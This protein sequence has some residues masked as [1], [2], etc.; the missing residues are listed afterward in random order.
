MTVCRF[1]QQGCCRFGNACRFEHVFAQ[2]YS[3]QGQQQNNPYKVVNNSSQANVTTE[4]L[5]NQVSSDTSAALNGHQWR[6]SSYGPFKCKPNFPGMMDI[7]P[8]EL[9]YQMYEARTNGVIPQTEAQI[10]QYLVEATEKLKALTKPSV[11]IVG[12]IESVYRNENTTDPFTTDS[13]NFNQNNS[14]VFGNNNTLAQPANV[15]AGA[16]QSNAS[17]SAAG[18][19]FAE[20]AQNIFQTQPQGV[21]GGS[22]AFNNPKPAQIETSQNNN[23][24]TFNTPEFNQQQNAVFGS[25]VNQPALNTANVFSQPQTGISPAMLFASANNALT[26]PVAPSPSNV[27]GQ[28]ANP[29]NANVAPPDVFGSQAPKPFQMQPSNNVFSNPSNVSN[30]TSNVNPFGTQASA[31]ACPELYS[32]IE[33]LTEEDLA[34]FKS[35][36]FLRGQIPELPPPLELCD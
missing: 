1:Y 16:M 35:D 31:K 3:N 2:N 32:K 4:Q 29:T 11:P 21:F 20:A 6:I 17:S 26:A 23:F 14:N 9:R 27:F 5:I 13:L 12:V 19:L 25:N 36:V 33:N 15:F 22:N 34:A 7:S 18:S 10:A 8:E 28:P 24:A 30:P